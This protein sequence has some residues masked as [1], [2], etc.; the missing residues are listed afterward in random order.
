MKESF[1]KWRYSQ[2]VGKI[3]EKAFNKILELN[4]KHSK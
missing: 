4:H 1:S 3:A 2:S